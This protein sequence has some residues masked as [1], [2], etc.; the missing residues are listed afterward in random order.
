MWRC[1]AQ[2]LLE[3]SRDLQKKIELL[4]TKDVEYRIL[5]CLAESARSFGTRSEAGE[6]AIPLSQR[7]VASLI[8]AT[9]ETTST[10]LNQMARRGQIRLGRRQ[11]ILTALNGASI[12]EAY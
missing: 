6:Y 11:L 8:G 4:C 12:A 5:H 3:R 7:E 9:R 2:L 1:L 10:T